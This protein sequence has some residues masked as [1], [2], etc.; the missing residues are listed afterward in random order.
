MFGT[1]STR[2][3]AAIEHKDREAMS[4]STRDARL[5]RLQS[6]SLHGFRPLRARRTGV[7]L[8]TIGKFLNF[9]H[10]PSGNIREAA[11][12]LLVRKITA[13][14]NSL[15]LLIGNSDPT[16]TFVSCMRRRAYTPPRA[17]QI[18]TCMVHLATARMKTSEKT[19]AS[20]FTLLRADP[21]TTLLVIVP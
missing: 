8:S 9:G 6:A 13:E 5:G 7:N 1:S 4:P 11:P 19:F 16:A 20:C 10:H 18:E 15:A 21:S 12:Q 2:G 3:T 17:T 14:S